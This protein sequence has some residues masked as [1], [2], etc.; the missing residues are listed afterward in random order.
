MPALKAVFVRIKILTYRLICLPIIYYMKLELFKRFNSLTVL[1]VSLAVLGTGCS[2]VEDLYKGADDEGE[3]LLSGVEVSANFKWATSKTIDVRLAVD[4]QYNGQ[5]YYKL[6]LFDLEPHAPGASLLGAGLARKGQDLVTKITIPEGLSHIYVQE[7]TPQ[8]IVSYSMLEVGGKAS[9]ASSKSASTSKFAGTSL[10]GLNKMSSTSTST[11]STPVDAPKV[12]TNAVEL[13]GKN[14]VKHADVSAN[15]NF[16][17]RKGKTFTGDIALNAGVSGI[18]VYVE[19]VWNPKGGT[20]VLGA[21]NTINVLPGTK[22]ELKKLSMPST[23]IKFANFG[24]SSFDD[25][26]ANSKSDISNHGTLSIA[27]TFDIPSDTK[28]ENTGV[29]S[30]KNMKINSGGEFVNIGTATLTGILDMPANSTYTNEGK[31][32]VTNFKG[33]STAVITNNGELIIE[34]A[35][36]ANTT[37]F[38]NCRTIIGKMNLNGTVFNIATGGRLDVDDVKVGGSK[39]N[40][41]NGAILDVVDKMEFTSNS[42]TVTALGDVAVARF[43]KVDI[44]GWNGVVY[45]GR[46]TVA[47]KE[48]TQ[49]EKDKLRYTAGDQVKMVKYNAIS[50]TI[51]GTE[52][53]GGGFNYTPTTPPEDQ[54]LT[55]VVLGTYSYAFEDNWPSQGDYDMND[56]VVDVQIVKYQNKANKVEKIVLKNK[57]RSVGASKRLAAAFQ[58][59]NVL[60]AT[61]KSVTYSNRDVVGKVLPLTSTGVEDG[62]AKAVVTLV[63]D[64][65]KAF[66]RTDNSF[67]FTEDGSIQPLATE[68][69]IEFTT[70]LE[71]F[72]YTDLNA[73]IVNFAQNQGGRNEVHLVGFNATDKIN[74]SLVQR[75]QEAGGALSSG[76]PFKTK[77]NYP[78]AMSFPLSFKYPLEGQDITK[79]YPDFEEWVKSVG[80]SSQFWYNNKK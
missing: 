79:V 39:F 38:V 71:N 53:N 69:T 33:N 10:Q 47:S 49:N 68:I 1:A 30:T 46:L 51:A 65:H 6:E 58:L 7:T 76:D 61:V 25:F 16:V 18:T 12:P 13:E 32:K 74:K 20:V 11:Y 2:K 70:A 77:G 43:G 45:E 31:A 22:F 34:D 62:Q 19:G 27:N 14:D 64:A 59:D 15:K 72:N 78:F 57:I 35:Q 17:I 9:V 63:D 67:V 21:G 37:W 36:I 73:F 24:T 23:N 60:A 44:S 4:D 50:V 28:F 80:A 56:L 8:G 66:G 3:G 42:S 48:H 41:A 29:L 75:E 54:K 52:C 40:L 55:E 26:E 5:F